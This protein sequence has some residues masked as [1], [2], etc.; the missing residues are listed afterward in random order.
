MEK[1]EKYQS[2]SLEEQQF[3]IGGSWPGAGLVNS[4]YN[5]G[6]DVGHAIAKWI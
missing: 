3:T 6:K 4:I 1:L 5:V 2:L